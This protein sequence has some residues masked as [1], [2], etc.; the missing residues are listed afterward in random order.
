VSKGQS[1]YERNK[2][3][4]DDET[5]YPDHNTVLLINFLAELAV[6]TT[7]AKAK[8]D[9]DLPSSPTNAAHIFPSRVHDIR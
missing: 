4:L 7:L 5:A 9:C 6:E 2:K 3:I 1:K 8:L